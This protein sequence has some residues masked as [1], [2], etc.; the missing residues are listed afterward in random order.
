MIDVHTLEVVAEPRQLAESTVAN[1]PVWQQAAQRW[2]Y[3]ERTAA[4]R[5]IG[6][7]EGRNH[8]ITTVLVNRGAGCIKLTSAQRRT[9]RIN[10][11]GILRLYSLAEAFERVDK[12]LESL[13]LVTTVGITH[14]LE[15]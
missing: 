5:C 10:R 8:H 9:R 4:H 7:E 11:S 13:A 1:R 12:L 15:G 2:E 6:I 14:S 3:R